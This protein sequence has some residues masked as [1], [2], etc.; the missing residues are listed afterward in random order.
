MR[1]THMLTQRL[2]RLL[3]DRA[4]YSLLALDHGLTYGHSEATSLPPGGMLESCR[5]H[6]GGFVMNYGIAHALDSWP[7]RLSLVLQCFG[8]LLGNSRHQVATVQ[9][10]VVLDAAAVAVQLSWSDSEIGPRMREISAF[11][12]DAHS[13]GLPVLYMLG[14]ECRIKDLPRSIRVCQEMG[15][16]LIKINCST[17]RFLADEIAVTDALRNGPPTLMA[18]GATTSDIFQLAQ[19][20]AQLGF[21]G[22]CIGRNIFSAEDPSSVV[23]RLNTIF[24]TKREGVK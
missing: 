3:G 2:N 9:Q 22:Y 8:G 4:F 19:N 11:T 13:A 21:S 17:D 5:D 23:A 14:G 20:A 16:N 18:G 6:L 24:S 7:V 15:A 1:S 10:A 12:A